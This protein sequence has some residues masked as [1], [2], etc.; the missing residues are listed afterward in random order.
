MLYTEGKHY[1]YIM[2]PFAAKD[3]FNMSIAKWPDSRV[4]NLEASIT[5][6][7]QAIQFPFAELPLFKSHIHP[8]LAIYNFGMK[9]EAAGLIPNGPGASL[10]GLL[11]QLTLPGT[12]D[13]SRYATLKA[14]HPSLYNAVD[15][16]YDLYREQMSGIREP[17]SVHHRANAPVYDLA[18][19]FDTPRVTRSQSATT[20]TIIH[21]ELNSSEKLTPVVNARSPSTSSRDSTADVDNGRKPVGHSKKSKRATRG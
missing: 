16:C 2:F 15:V 21:C 9:I 14:A 12:K 5:D 20:G 6:C 3:N 10:S 13:I 1:T 19:F 7:P 11:L 4:S 18:S 8:I 17:K